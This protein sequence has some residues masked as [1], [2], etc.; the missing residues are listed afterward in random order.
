[1]PKGGYEMATA[2]WRAAALSRRSS[3][4]WRRSLGTVS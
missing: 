1:M 2:S 4:C 3:R